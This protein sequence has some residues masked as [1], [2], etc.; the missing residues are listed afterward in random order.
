MMQMSKDSFLD[1]DII[2]K[3]GA[4][5]CEKFLSEI[6]L[7]LGYNL[8]IHEYLIQK[9]LIMQGGALN[10]FNKMIEAGEIIEIKVSDLNATESAE[11]NS[12]LKLLA[13]EMCVDL[14]NRHERKNVGE[15]KSMAMAFAKGY[16]YFIS[17]D[18]EARVAS[19]KILQNF[20]GSYLKTIQMVDIIEHIRD[21]Y[22]RLG[23]S[24]NITKKLYLYHS[25]PKSARNDADKIKLTRIHTI[26]KKNFDETLWPV[27]I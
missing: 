12:T 16:G 14:S 17:D 23:I 3:I 7:D 10:Q 21:N 6:L 11:Y 26:L 15:V 9:E 1:T 2:L 20:D 22:E 8:Y 24:R 19:K 27:S 13:T 4:F 5:R 25:N 18:K